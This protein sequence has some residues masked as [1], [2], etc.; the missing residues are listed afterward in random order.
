VLWSIE[1][2]AEPVSMAFK[3]FGWLLWYEV[4]LR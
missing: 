3:G 4:R 1:N 2:H